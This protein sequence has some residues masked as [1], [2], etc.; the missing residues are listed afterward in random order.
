MTI[1]RALC[2]LLLAVVVS[3]CEALDKDVVTKRPLV[4]DVNVSN[5]LE[6]T[7][8]ASRANASPTATGT[9]LEAYHQTA[10]GKALV[11]AD[12]RYA[13]E[14]AKKSLE[15]A[16]DNETTKWTNPANGHTGTFTPLNSYQSD[17][18]YH[19]R[20]FEQSITADGQTRDTRGAAC[21]AGPN[22]W[23]VVEVPITRERA[24]GTSRQRRR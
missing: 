10:V 17:D 5:R 11:S 21:E 15:T 19:C 14:A 4:A 22:T 20:D 13:E 3:G 16:P 18:R 12:R 8:G 24:G 1:A 7:L 9:L 2:V 6:S 23:K